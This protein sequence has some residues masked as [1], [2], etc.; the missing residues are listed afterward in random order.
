MLFM[1]PSFIQFYFLQNNN[2][3]EAVYT[4]HVLKDT[5]GKVVC[6]A[7][8]VYVCPICNNTGHKVSRGDRAAMVSTY[9]IVTRYRP[10]LSN[11]VP[12]IPT[13]SENKQSWRKSGK[14]TG[15]FIL[16]CQSRI[17][18]HTVIPGPPSLR[19]RLL[20]SFS[21]AGPGPW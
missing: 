11:T 21:T 15:I 18:P 12:T 10:T 8:Y 9:H 4:S 17:Q 13:H 2:E 7:L 5:D 1:N 14:L 20:W 6:P 16:F 19:L 3:S